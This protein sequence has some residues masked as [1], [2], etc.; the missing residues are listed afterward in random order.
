MKA[1]PTRPSPEQATSAQLDTRHPYP[2]PKG[3]PDAEVLG[4]LRP[5]AVK[6]GPP[7]PVASPADPLARWRG[8]D[9]RWVRACDALVQTSGRATGQGIAWTAQAN[10]IPRLGP[11]RQAGTGRRAIARASAS[12][13]ASNLAPVT[14]FGTTR[15]AT[16]GRTAVTR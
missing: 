12:P 7:R 5:D 3:V 4:Q 8:Q 13:R 16:V 11:S 1:D 14:A 2:T 6:P 10:R 9:V 15:D